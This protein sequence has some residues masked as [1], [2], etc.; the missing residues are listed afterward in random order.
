MTEKGMEQ[1]QRDVIKALNECGIEVNTMEITLSDKLSPTINYIEIT[2]TKKE[3][4]Q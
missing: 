1:W 3:V 2:G 4:K